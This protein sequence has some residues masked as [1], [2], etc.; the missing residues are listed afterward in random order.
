MIEFSGSVNSSGGNSQ[1]HYICDVKDKES[2]KWFRTN[3]NRSPVYIE[4]KNIS[5]LPYV[6]LYKRMLQ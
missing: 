5:N 3:D 6:V 4:E 2:N 1:G